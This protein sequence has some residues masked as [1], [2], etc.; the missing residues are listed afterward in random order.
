LRPLHDSEAATDWHRLTPLVQLT[1]SSQV[2]H[3]EGTPDPA[4]AAC[5]LLPKQHGEPLNAA[6]QRY[7]PTGARS[8]GDPFAYALAV[9]AQ[10]I[11]GARSGRVNHKKS[12]HGFFMVD[13]TEPP[14][15]PVGVA[16]CAQINYPLT[17]SACVVDFSDNGHYNRVA[18]AMRRTRVL[19]CADISL[20]IVQCGGSSVVGRSCI[21]GKS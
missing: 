16:G 5:C 17:T 4:R 19:A 9:R 11:E 3:N 1:D 21:W 15:S 13:A 7:K 8:R 10:G 12:M 2:N 6:L 14:Q 18:G 20:G